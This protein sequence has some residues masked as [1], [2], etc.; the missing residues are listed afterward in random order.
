[1]VAIDVQ[2][3]DC[4]IA[5]RAEILYGHGRSLRLGVRQLH[6]DWGKQ[7]TKVIADYVEAERLEAAKAEALVRQEEAAPRRI[8]GKSAPPAAKSDV[9][10]QS[11]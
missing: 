3:A 4:T 8:R 5:C 7:A 9:V 1:M 11:E 2:L 10:K 6:I